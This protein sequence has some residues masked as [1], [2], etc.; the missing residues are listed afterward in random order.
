M[1]FQIFISHAEEDAT[2][3]KRVHRILERMELSPWIYERYSEF[4]RDLD[5]I[6]R[7][8]ISECEHFITLLT[9]NGVRSQWVNQEIGMAYASNKNII[10]V[11]EKGLESKG[12]IGFKLAIPYDPHKVEYSISLLIYRL[13][14]L[15]KPSQIR[16]KC[17]SC[18]NE[19]SYSLPTQKLVNECIEDGSAV[20]IQ[21]GD[22]DANIVVNP[23][24]LEVVR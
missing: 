5:D 10:P 22:C 19:S 23:Q 13:R 16:Y 20:T 15:M 14:V 7:D 17:R 12:F 11:V 4:G 1:P 2:L 24:T 8:K 3:A 21:C 6:I 9:S 18:G